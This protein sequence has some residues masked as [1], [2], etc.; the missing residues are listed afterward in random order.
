MDPEV[1]NEEEEAAACEDIRRLAATLAPQMSALDDI[2]RDYSVSE[3]DA[4]ELVEDEDDDLDDFEEDELDEY[5]LMPPAPKPALSLKRS[6]KPASGGLSLKR[7][8]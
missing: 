7:N 4:R 6:N 5:R 8:R 2:L 3:K 1:Y